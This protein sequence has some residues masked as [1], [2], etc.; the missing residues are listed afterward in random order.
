MR[1]CRALLNRAMN[2]VVT[3]TM[4]VISWL[5][6]QLAFE[7]FV[8]MDFIGC[9]LCLLALGRLYICVFQSLKSYFSISLLSQ[10]HVRMSTS[11]FTAVLR[12]YEQY[13]GMCLNRR[14]PKNI[15]SDVRRE[16]VSLIFFSIP[17]IYLTNSERHSQ[18]CLIHISR[19]ALDTSHFYCLEVSTLQ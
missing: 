5:A 4:Q 2:Q 18:L 8:F 17:L 7:V 19:S 11:C 10:S 1:Q 13:C 3:E 15:I 12:C 14:K 16:I 9:A 6:K